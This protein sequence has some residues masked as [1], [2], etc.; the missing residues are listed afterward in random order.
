MKNIILSLLNQRQKAYIQSR[1]CRI[2]SSEDTYSK[3]I[4]IEMIYSKVYN[5]IIKTADRYLKPAGVISKGDWEVYI[6]EKSRER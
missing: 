5:E 4:L 6:F 3:A 1:N 2:S